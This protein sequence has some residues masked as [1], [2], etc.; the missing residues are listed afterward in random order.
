MSGAIW[1]IQQ[2][3]SAAFPFLLLAAGV[4]LLVAIHDGLEWFIKRGLRRRAERL[5]HQ[6]S[7]DP[8]TITDREVESLR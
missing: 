8:S 6:W 2:A 3:F 7:T 5:N 4:A 1:F